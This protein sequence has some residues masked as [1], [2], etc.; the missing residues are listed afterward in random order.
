MDDYQ[1]EIQTG[2]DDLQIDASRAG[3][4]VGTKFNTDF[5]TAAAMWEQSALN[6][7]NAIRAQLAV[8]IPGPIIGP[9]QFT[10]DFTTGDEEPTS[11]GGDDN[12]MYLINTE[13]VDVERAAEEI[14][15]VAQT[16]RNLAG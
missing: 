3:N 13:G 5:N 16:T 15:A 9:A 6:Q 4:L 2:Y 10:D 7:M 8:P 11:G 14:Q 12:R 1:T